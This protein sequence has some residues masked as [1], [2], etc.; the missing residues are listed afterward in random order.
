MSYKQ[1]NVQS[2]NHYVLDTSSALEVG[3]V[4]KMILDKLQSMKHPYSYNQI[5][6]WSRA[7]EYLTRAFFKNGVEDLLKAKQYIDSVIDN[8][9]VS[10]VSRRKAAESYIG[11]DDVLT[12]MLE[13]Q[14]LVR[15]MGGGA[16]A[17]IKCLFEEVGEL[18]ESLNVEHEIETQATRALNILEL[19]MFTRTEEP[20]IEGIDALADII[21]CALGAL[22]QAVGSKKAIQ[23]LKEVNRA[24][25]SKFDS[26]NKPIFNEAGKVTKG[27][28]YLPPDLLKIL[29]K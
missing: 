6:S 26:S 20:N 5:D 25:W 16:N 28:W 29:N 8:I 17:Q 13:W 18:V 2:P 21:V 9:S 10:E 14:E 12:S 7:W 11:P 15:P 19:L 4:R 24:N 1:D 23:V 3:D 22:Q 27:P